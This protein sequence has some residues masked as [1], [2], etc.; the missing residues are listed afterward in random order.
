MLQPLFKKS[1]VL[2]W[3]KP[4]W[5]R[6]CLDAFLFE[7]YKSP[8]RPAAVSNAVVIYTWPSNHVTLLR[9]QQMLN[10]ISLDL[11]YFNINLNVDCTSLAAGEG[12]WGLGFGVWGLGFGVWGYAFCF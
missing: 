10:R 7:C 4:L 2:D 9:M 12:V 3:M 6:Q 1:E 5:G 8:A 11:S